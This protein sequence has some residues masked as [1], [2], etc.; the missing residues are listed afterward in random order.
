MAQ[1]LPL[2][3]EA[4]FGAASSVGNALSCRIGHLKLKGPPQLACLQLSADRGQFGGIAAKDPNQAFCYL[5]ILS[6]FSM[7]IEVVSQPPFVFQLGEAPIFLSLLLPLT[8]QQWERAGGK[9]RNDHPLPALA[10][11]SPGRRKVTARIPIIQ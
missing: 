5:A 3:L 6:R 10:S 7:P 11:M 4:N 9:T 2:V 1:D 8:S